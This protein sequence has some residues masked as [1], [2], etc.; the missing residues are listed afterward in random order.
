MKITVCGGLNYGSPHKRYLKDLISVPM[1]VTLFGK[2]V[3]ANAIKL[4]QD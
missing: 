2:T 4:N 3:F 1:D